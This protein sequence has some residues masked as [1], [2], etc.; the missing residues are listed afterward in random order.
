MNINQLNQAA[1]GVHVYPDGRM[2]TKSASAYLG[3][4]EGT[5]AKMRLE[6]TG[7]EFVRVGRKRIFYQQNALDA[8]VKAGRGA[9]A[10]QNR[11]RCAGGP[12]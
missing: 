3:L 4:A 1:V 10:P 6:G 2:D 11:T 8:F 7:P 9:P 5:L 12:E